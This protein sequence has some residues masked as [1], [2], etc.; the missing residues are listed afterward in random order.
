MTPYDDSS[1][2]TGYSWPK[3]TYREHYGKGA[4]ITTLTRSYSEEYPTSPVRSPLL[5]SVI[6]PFEQCEVTNGWACEKCPVHKN[7]LKL[8]N[9]IV[10]ADMKQKLDST[11]AREFIEAFEVLRARGSKS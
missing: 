2:H 9:R 11:L 8:F 6:R 1:D 4:E 5:M 10:E 7:C 3:K